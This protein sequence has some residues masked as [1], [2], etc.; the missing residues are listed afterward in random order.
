MPLRKAS[1]ISPSNSSFS[2][3]SAMTLL[4]EGVAGARE[5]APAEPH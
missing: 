5:R 4:S 1:T 3:F 2:S